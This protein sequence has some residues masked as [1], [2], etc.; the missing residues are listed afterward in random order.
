MIQI[1]PDPHHERWRSQQVSWS[2]QAAL[3]IGHRALVFEGLKPPES[4][5]PKGMIWISE[6]R[7]TWLE[8]L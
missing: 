7:V 3:G 1:A 8:N 2:S 5:N 6:V 4:G